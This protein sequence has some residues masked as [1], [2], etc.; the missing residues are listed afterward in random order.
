M[1]LA[2]VIC[3]SKFSGLNGQSIKV[4][5]ILMSFQESSLSA[6]KIEKQYFQDKINRLMTLEVTNLCQKCLEIKVKA[7]KVQFA[8]YNLV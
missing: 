7:G 2:Q 4:E 3:L 1:A 6:L 5:A 8:P